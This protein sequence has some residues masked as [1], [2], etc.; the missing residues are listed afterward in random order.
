MVIIMFVS[1]NSDTPSA[2]VVKP[3]SGRA[4]AVTAGSGV[5]SA[6]LMPTPRQT[7]NGVEVTHPTAR[8]VPDY[9]NM[10]HARI[11]SPR[12]APSAI[13]SENFLAARAS[14]SPGFVHNAA[15]SNIARISNMYRDAPRFRN[16]IDI[17]V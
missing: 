2:G 9:T 14:L 6:S 10:Q 4:N 1:S 11:Y 7:I 16:E 15:Q 3:I 5:S 8:S 17:L 12:Q 13:T